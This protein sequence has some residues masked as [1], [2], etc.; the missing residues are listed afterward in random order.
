MAT[1]IEINSQFKKALEVMES[2][3]SVFITGKAGTGKSTLL[4]YFRYKTSKNIAVLAPTGV[5]AVNVRGQTIHSFFGFRPDITVDKVK[6]KYRKIR[7]A[8]LYKK[9]EALVIDEISMVRADL[10]DC[11][12]AFLRMHGKDKG[13]PFGGIQMVF[14]GD[15]YQLPPVV[16]GQER[17]IFSTHYPSPY[18]FDA[19]IFNQMELELIELEKIYRQKDE[20]FIRILN[21]VRNRSIDEVLLDELNQR[22]D[23][24]FEP[25]NKDVFIHLVTTNSR[26]S[27]INDSKLNC[28]PGKMYHYQGLISGEFDEKALPAPFNLSLKI[29]SQV[30]LT[31]NDR[32][33]RW[34]NGTVGNVFR[35]EKDEE[36]DIIWVRLEG[37]EVVDVYPYRWEMFKFTFNE[38]SRKIESETTGSFTQYP[39]I[40]AWAITI[41]KSQ[42]KTFPKA[43]VDLERGTFAHGQAYV[44]LSRCVSLEGLVLKTPIKKTHLLLDFRVVKFLT[45]FQYKKSD[46][47]LSVDEKAKIIKNAIKSSQEIEILYLKA[48]DEKSKRVVKPEVIGEMDYQGKKFLGFSGFDQLRGEERVFRVDRIL[49]IKT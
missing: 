35:I 1:T 34:V 48:S 39:V 9:L 49:E 14:I 21:A 18:F 29:G 47:I 31:N 26:A 8:N 5:A 10:L 6:Q 16:T 24:D 43:V 22:V 33:A 32:E 3:Q 46:Q 25:E 17:K 37:G 27:Q 41:H 44:A 7:N 28:L 19:Q 15:L 45:S 36:G 23:I 12:D 30:M 11:M 13:K 20:A 38:N 42:G 2:G 40:L 4:E